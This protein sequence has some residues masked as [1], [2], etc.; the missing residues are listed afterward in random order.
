MSR[1]TINEYLTDIKLLLFEGSHLI[2]CIQCMPQ[3]ALMLAIVVLTSLSFDKV[4][5]SRRECLVNL[6]SAAGAQC[7][8]IAALD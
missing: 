3:N 4:S 5:S 7:V 6:S 2:V 8:I 1:Q